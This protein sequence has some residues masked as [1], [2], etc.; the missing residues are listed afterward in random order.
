MRLLL[1][2]CSAIGL[3]VLVK[4]LVLAPDPD[5]ALVSPTGQA[6]IVFA[7]IVGLFAVLYAKGGRRRRR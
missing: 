1:F 5:A 4:Y 2:T 6:V 7:L 3:Y